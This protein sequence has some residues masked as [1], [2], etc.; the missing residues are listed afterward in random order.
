MGVL[1]TG[2]KIQFADSCNELCVTKELFK[3]HF[4]SMANKKE[5][6]A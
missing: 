3:A 6:D 4:R 2:E 5:T 1:K